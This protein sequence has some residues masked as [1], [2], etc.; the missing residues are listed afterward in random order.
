[1][2]VTGGLSVVLEGLGPTS[3][4]LSVVDG[5]TVVDAALPAST[6]MTR[7]ASSPL[8][9][10][11]A[12]VT[13]TAIHDACIAA[14]IDRMVEA[15]PG[16]W[17]RAGVWEACCRR[18]CWSQSHRY[19]A[20]MGRARRS[21]PR[22]E[23]AAVGV[24]R[25]VRLV[26]RVVVLL[27]VVM[28][29]WSVLAATPAGAC[30][31]TATNDAE[32]FGFAEAVFVGA[33]VALHTTVDSSALGAYQAEVT[34]AVERVYKGAVAAEQV[35]LTSNSEASCGLA[36]DIG[37]PMLVFAYFGAPGTT[38]ENRLASHLCSGSRPADMVAIPDIF[39]PGQQIATDPPASTSTQPAAISS[40]SASTAQSPVSTSEVAS[41][42]ADRRPSSTW[43]VVGLAAA[44]VAVAGVLAAASGRWRRR[45]RQSP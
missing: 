9:Q 16:T 6:V 19:G 17:G 7:S 41:A 29:S 22:R 26:G 40:R 31:C 35:I 33:P 21:K 39:G 2:F 11:K 36:V 4:A 8:E 23:K 34:F 15:L 38:G 13:M 44:G 20:W 14:L 43:T 45:H 18:D 37:S 25:A 1:M 3:P 32:A 27:G 5:E 42:S 12:S 10:P 30:S 28:G 24:G